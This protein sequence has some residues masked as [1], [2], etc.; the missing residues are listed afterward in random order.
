VRQR[1]QANGLTVHG[2]GGTHVVLLGL[3]I[4]ADKRAGLLGFA[5]QREDHVEDE[6]YWLKGMKA[7]A[8]TDPGL[9]PGGQASSREQPFQTFQWADYSAKPDRPYTYTVVPLYGTPS[10]LEEGGRV[11][12]Q[13]RTEA[14]S[15]AAH[16]VFFNRGAAASQ[17]YARRFENKPPDE[18][19]TP[20]FKWLSRGLLEAMRAFI[21]RAS[22]SG[23]GLYGAIY[24]FQHPDVLSAI[25]AA[26]ASGAKVKVI[27][28]AV[29]NADKSPLTKNAAAIAGAHIKSRCKG[30]TK[31]RLMHNKFLVLTR[32]VNGGDQPL[33]VWTGST[34]ATVN[35]LFGHSN[36]GHVVEDAGIAGQFLA[37]W[38]ELLTDPVAKDLKD[39]TEGQN[40][41]PP[42]PGAM[43]PD[44]IAFFSPRRG[45][46]VLDWYAA[47]AGQ[48][49]EALFMTFAFGMHK[50]LL[51]VYDRADPVL[52]FALM[53]KEG[54]GSGLAQ[55]RID[56]RR[57]RRRPNVL[58]AIGGRIVTNRF[59]RWLREIDRVVAEAHV[60]WIHT[61]YMLVDPLGAAPA[62]VTGSA[63]FSEAS[64]DTNDENMLVIRNDRRV[65]DIYLGEYMRL[66][67]HYAFREAVRIHFEQTGEVEDWKPNFLV[68]DDSWQ[69]EYFQD[70]NDRSLRRRYFAR[71]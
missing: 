31:A 26:G 19:G 17:E 21:G 13:V 43:V 44:T 24:E 47:L 16:S 39:W 67:S 35:G 11:A 4:V 38:R 50:S 14:E 62:V 1:Q 55:A 8:E 70:G 60:L 34:N 65:A 64:T 5:I 25:K 48:A 49:Q 2:I 7:F 33:A 52:R 40:Q 9:G 20:A 28:D 61:K 42:A 10:Q 51:A 29:P 23:F 68:P 36:C 54:T 15:G 69:A 56:I 12:V 37:Y 41:A 32:R 45:L 46:R 22:G 59:D 3:D 53:E 57:V 63:N 66:Y 58:I 30:R 71:T 6:R 18:V 27:Y